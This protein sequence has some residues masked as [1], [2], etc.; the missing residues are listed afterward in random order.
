MNLVIAGQLLSF[1]CQ[2]LSLVARLPV[3]V[4]ILESSEGSDPRHGGRVAT[5]N[6]VRPVAAGASLV[7]RLLA[8]ETVL[9]A[10]GRVGREGSRKVMRRVGLER[11][12]VDE[13]GVVEFGETHG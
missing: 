4:G 3:L 10:T 8:A 6:Q 2:P 13:V 1:I 7:P 12:G 5:T 9:V 11:G